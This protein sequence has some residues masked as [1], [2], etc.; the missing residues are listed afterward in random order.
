MRKSIGGA[1]L[2]LLG[3][4][5]VTFGLAASAGAISGGALSSVT[6]SCTSVTITYGETTVDRDNTGMGN[7]SITFTVTDGNGVILAD[8]SGDYPVGNALPAQT[9]TL[10]YDV[11][12]TANPIRLLLVSDA[13]NGL[14]EQAFYDVSGTCGQFPTTT[15]STSTSST[16][17]S[18]TSTTSTTV[19]GSTTTLSIPPP[20]PSTTSTLATS[21]TVPSSSTV[22]EPDGSDDD[23]TTTT[24]APPAPSQPG[25]AA[26]GPTGGSNGGILGNN[27]TAARPS[28][29]GQGLARTGTDTGNLVALGIVLMSC[30]TL[31]LLLR[32]R[33]HA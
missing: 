16:S 23:G 12:V 5:S 15:T 7:E 18:T 2:L 21:S 31:L 1:L 30:G 10:D 20:P 13:G 4:A 9:E 25:T 27:A 26:P 28:V 14:P 6:F 17:T 11:P 19:P 8:L 24:Q 22:S 3:L 32:R 29:A 33:Q